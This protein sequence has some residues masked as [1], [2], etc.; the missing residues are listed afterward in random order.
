MF[1]LLTLTLGSCRKDKDSGS[2]GGDKTVKYEMT[3][4]FTGKI[5][6]VTS[7]NSGNLQQFDNVTMP[8]SREIKYGSTVMA[9][10]IGFNGGGG[11]QGGAPGQTITLKVYINNKLKDTK[12]IV[13]DA[14][15]IVNHATSFYT[16]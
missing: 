12:Q 13:A 3:G 15:G 2:S 9:A 16:F 8:W 7:T 14:S 4:N 11:G 5:T 6:V 1:L 10:G